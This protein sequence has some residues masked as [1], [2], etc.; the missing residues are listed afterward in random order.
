MNFES[1]RHKNKQ[2]R[3]RFLQSFRKVRNQVVNRIASGAQK[4]TEEVTEESTVFAVDRAIDVI[5]IASQRIRERNISTE[6]VSLKISVKI[7]GFAEL[8]M[9]VDVPSSNQAKP[10]NERKI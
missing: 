7:A 3:E 9:Q 1:I 2:L 4:R 8:K 5:E 10:D 6:N